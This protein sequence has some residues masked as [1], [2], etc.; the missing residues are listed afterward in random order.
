MFHVVT[1]KYTYYTLLDL[2][3][4]IYI[5]IFVYFYRPTYKYFCIMYSVHC[6]L[7]EKRVLQRLLKY[8]KLFF[9]NV[10]NSLFKNSFLSTNTA[11]YSIKEY[12]ISLQI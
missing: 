8:R 10:E 2:I 1:Y 5:G 9:Y 4:L 7:L 6:T 11:K 12:S 3:I